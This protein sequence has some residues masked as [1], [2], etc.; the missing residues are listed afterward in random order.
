MASLL[1]PAGSVPVA[2]A[3]AVPVSACS[4]L[5]RDLPELMMP[6]GTGDAHSGRILRLTLCACCAI[7]AGAIGWSAF[8]QVSEA[9]GVSGTL[10]PRASERSLAHADGGVV[11]RVLVEEGDRVRAGQVLVEMDAA[12]AQG[13]S[14]FASERLADL[15]SQL[16]DLDALDIGPAATPAAERAGARLRGAAIEAR[17]ETAAARTRQQAANVATL[18]TQLE[19][20]QRAETI[21]REDL[22]RAR[23]LFA[24]EA[25]SRSALNQRELAYSDAHGR[26]AALRRQIEAAR[27]ALALGRSEREGQ[28][29]GQALDLFAEHNRL[30]LQRSEARVL[31]DHARLRLARRQLRAPRAGVI[32]ALAVREGS[33]V[34]PSGEVAVLVPEGELVVEAR[35]LASE[36]QG[37]RP[38]LPAKLR[39]TG[40]DVPGRGWIDARVERISPSS[41]ADPSGSHYYTL[42][43]AIA[44]GPELREVLGELAAGMEVTGTIV[45]GHKSVL[46]YVLGP[47]RH[48]LD[49]ALSEK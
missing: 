13:E 21:A 45:T 37:L 40:F 12:L 31:L 36:R 27:E 9:A 5:A 17:D 10:Q 33:V 49:S 24:A 8:A 47:V 4:A 35:V 1:A 30:A 43:L 28:A 22:D 39:V 14:A 25:T 32:K 48:G 6:I 38:G 29:A 46:A 23:R 20:A 18:R 3:Q 11:A 26:V 16:A 2:P 34:V 7:A 42:R 15:D 41:F 44:H 19:T